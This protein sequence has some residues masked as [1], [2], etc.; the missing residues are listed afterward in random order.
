MTNPYLFSLLVLLYS[1]SLGAQCTLEPAIYGDPVLCPEEQGLLYT[2]TFDTYQWYRT[3]WGS[4]DA[5]AIP[6]AN[7]MSLVIS[8][9]DLLYRIHVEVS[10]DTCTGVSEEVLVDGWVFP[11]P[12]V[13]NHGNYNYDPAVDAFVGCEGDT[14]WLELGLPYTQSITWIRNGMAIP[15]ENGIYLEITTPG[16]YTVEAA[17]E[18][19]PR[20]IQPL[21]LILTVVVEDCST[22]VMPPDQEW[23]RMYPNPVADRI[24]LEGTAPAGEYTLVSADG[25]YAGRFFC[26]EGSCQFDV[27][28]LPTGTYYLR[29]EG[30]A[31]PA[32]PVVIRR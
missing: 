27:S 20:Y 16:N 10:Q 23:L 7:S 12:F 19:C 26:P 30:S 8:E 31:M 3:P 1:A 32:R 5:E 25:K 29:R 14:M 28:D 15:G 21:G 11:P 18:V 6:G 17:P 4:N 2:D 9:N 13:I 22:S 24:Y